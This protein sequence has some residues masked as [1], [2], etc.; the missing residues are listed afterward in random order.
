MMEL[1]NV[2]S[3]LNKTFPMEPAKNR[4]QNAYVSFYISR[5]LSV[6]FDSFNRELSNCHMRST[7]RYTVQIPEL[8]NP[9]VGEQTRYISNGLNHTSWNLFWWF[10]FYLFIFLAV[11]CSLQDLTW[12]DQGSNLGPWQWTRRILDGQETPFLSPMGWNFSSKAVHLQSCGVIKAHMPRE[13]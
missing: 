9:H 7:V 6:T 10:V 8:L 12:A 4:P 5:A 1:R 2:F 3:L 13:S 11:L